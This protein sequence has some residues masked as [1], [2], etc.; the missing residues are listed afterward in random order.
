MF[1]VRHRLRLVLSA[2]LLAGVP[3]RAQAV[4]GVVVEAGTSRPVA[5]VLVALYPESGGPAADGALT[6]ADG[7]FS[8]QAPPGRYTLRAEGVGYRTAS[9]AV[10]LVDGRTA[11]VRLET[12]AKTFVLPVVEVTAQTRCVVRPGAGMQAY[13]LWQQA[14]VA[15]RATALAQERGLVRYTVRTWHTEGMRRGRR[16]DPPRRVTGK[17]FQTLAPA[18]A[19]RH[20]YRR[21][22]GDTLSFYGPDARVLLS[23]E[24]LD[25]HCLYVQLQGGRPGEIGVAFEPAG[26]GAGVDIRG[27]LWLDGL[28]GELRSVDYEYTG[29]ED[30][31]RGTPSGGS[32]EFRR[33]E[34]GAWVVSRWRIRTARILRGP[35]WTPDRDEIIADLRESGGEVTDVELVPRTGPRTGEVR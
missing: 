35:G 5:G 3:L 17:P 16:R 12:A 28:S 8:L 19:A 13:E 4:R 15:L 2:A 24:F 9:A 7:R 10:E 25:A 29:L 11:Q 27:T 32:V 34:S 14:A 18:E 6:A 26:G 23:D 31:S 33:M 30:G 22:E 20:G 1:A 21:E